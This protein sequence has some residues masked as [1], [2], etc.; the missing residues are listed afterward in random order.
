[1]ENDLPYVVIIDGTLPEDQHFNKD[2]TDTLVELG[3]KPVFISYRDAPDKIELMKAA[4]SVIVAGVPLHY[5]NETAEELQPFL[6]LWLPEIETPVLGICLGHQAM[7]L[8]FGATMRRGEEVEEGT[9]TT[10]IAEGHQSDPIFEGLEKSFKVTT[11]HRASI[12]IEGAPQLVRLARSLPG[13]NSTG[14]ENQ[15]VRV[16][17]RQIYGVQFHPE[18]SEVGK[19]LLRNF[20][21]LSKQ[22]ALV[23]NF[24]VA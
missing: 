18:K 20:L 16:A 12:S 13:E 7:G 5:P 2:L 11:L 6:E 24:V 8:A 21:Q 3:Y 19:I 23:Q 14:C 10:E 15:V 1:M 4:H 22:T 17:G 9:V